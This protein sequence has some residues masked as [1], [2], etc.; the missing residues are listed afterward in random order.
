MR[1]IL[2]R[3]IQSSSINKLITQNTFVNSNSAID[4][5]IIAKVVAR[6]RF[7]LRPQEYELFITSAIEDI[8]KNLDTLLE[9]F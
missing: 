8:E 5:Y 7:V 3:P 6:D 4:N 2:Q 9:D 1:M